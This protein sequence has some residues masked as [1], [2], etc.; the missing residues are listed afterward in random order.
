MEDIEK[1][2]VTSRTCYETAISLS[3][4]STLVELLRRLA[5]IQNELGM[6]YMYDAQGNF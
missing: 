3:K 2:L 4:N 6:K 5:N 1:L